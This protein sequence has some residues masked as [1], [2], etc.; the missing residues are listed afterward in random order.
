MTHH[1]AVVTDSTSDIPAAEAARLKIQVIPA[2]V[3]IEG[4]THTD[5]EG[6]TREEFY[7]RLPSMRVPP[8]TAAPSPARFAEAYE[9]LFTSGVERILSIHVSSK[10][11]AI[12]GIA[13]QAAAA[14]GER[15]QVFDSAQVSLGLGFQAVEAAA[16]AL[17][18]ASF[19]AIVE[20][21]RRARDRAWTV[22]MIN[23]LEYLRRSGRVSWLRAGLG[24]LL[25]V[26]LLVEV[27]DGLVERLGQVRTRPSA[28]DQLCTI[29]EARAPLA[30]LA[31]LH[32]GI[33]D[34]A[35]ALARRLRTLSGAPPFTV[36]VTTVIGTHV[37]PRSIGA[38]GLAA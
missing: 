12:F 8:T 37:G 29:I 24:E 23:T 21:A 2:I 25:R 28:I 36:D 10:L 30:R 1:A 38:A 20:T 34:E 11:S 31:I 19:E 3:T 35:A 16:A 17:A 27:R 9:R 5:G 18:G 6:L 15:V 33:Q 13:H 4:Q 32:S 14:F 7:R 26:K 22:A